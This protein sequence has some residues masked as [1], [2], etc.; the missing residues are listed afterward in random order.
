MKSL[1]LSLGLVAAAV[2]AAAEQAPAAIMA[3]LASYKSRDSAERG[4]R[5][6][7]D[8]YSSVLYFS[9]QFRIVDL[10]GKGKFFRLYAEGD[11]ELMRMLCQSLQQRRMY[12]VLHDAGSLKPS[13]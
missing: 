11:E 1:L 12:C 13:R 10:D 2:P 8:H 7:A 9:P 6:L 4:W 3:H 5:V